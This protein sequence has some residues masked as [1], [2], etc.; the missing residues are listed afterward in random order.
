MGKLQ[1]DNTL[2]RS[3]I[4]QTAAHQSESYMEYHVWVML[5]LPVHEDPQ[6]PIEVV[7]VSFQRILQLADPRGIIAFRIRV[8]R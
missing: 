1:E 4:V 3:E 5:H 8:G 7:F 6:M 2:S